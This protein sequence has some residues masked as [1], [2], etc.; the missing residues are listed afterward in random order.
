VLRWFRDQLFPVIDDEQADIYHRML[1]TVGTTE[2]EG[3]CGDH[4]HKAAKFLKKGST[5][6]GVQQERLS[7]AVWA[8]LNTDVEVTFYK[9]TP[10]KS[11]D[12]MDAEVR[13]C[14][15]AYL[16]VRAQSVVCPRANAAPH[17]RCSRASSRSSRPGLSTPA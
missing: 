6:A 13:Q 9:F 16:P 5:R 11:L 7:T 17:R 3:G 1:C 12:D 2:T 15:Y 10:T 4:S 8:Q 14:C